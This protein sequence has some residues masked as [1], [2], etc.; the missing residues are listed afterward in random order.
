MLHM[1][2]LSK[3]VYVCVASLVQKSRQNLF[4]T[5][6]GTHGMA[7]NPSLRGWLKDKHSKKTALSKPGFRVPT[8]CTSSSIF[9]YVNSVPVPQAIHIKTVNSLHFVVFV[10]LPSEDK[11]VPNYCNAPSLMAYAHCQ[12]LKCLMSSKL[13]ESNIPLLAHCAIIWKID[14]LYSDIL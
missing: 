2:F 13:S 1:K 10:I 12:P 5:C 8:G 3:Y 7:H 6:L 14:L 4:C 9:P 11:T